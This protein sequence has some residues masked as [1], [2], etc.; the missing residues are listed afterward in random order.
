V[1][2][3]AAVSQHVDPRWLARGAGIGFVAIGAWTLWQAG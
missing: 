3:G 1:V 2:A